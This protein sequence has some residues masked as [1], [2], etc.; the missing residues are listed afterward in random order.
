MNVVRLSSR[1]AA[2]GLA[3]SDRPVGS[4]QFHLASRPRV[5]VVPEGEENPSMAGPSGR[6]GAKVGSPERGREASTRP[7]RGRMCE[8]EG[9]STI[10]STYN[11]STTCWLH[12][13][14]AYRHAL[15]RVSL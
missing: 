14:P 12:T 5:N 7:A 10:L 9:C 4:R 2:R 6:G 8:R 13:E 3:S 11:P 15:Y 1:A